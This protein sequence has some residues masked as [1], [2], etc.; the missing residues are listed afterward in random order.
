MIALAFA[1]S[2]RLVSRICCSAAA[3]AYLLIGGYDI[4]LA[5]IAFSITWQ[6]GN[7]KLDLR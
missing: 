6:A 7:A 2:P 4:L 5:A 1:R 3:T